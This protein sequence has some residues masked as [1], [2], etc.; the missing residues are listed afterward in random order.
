[1]KKLLMLVIIA[2]FGIAITISGQNFRGEV[3]KHEIYIPNNSYIG[4]SDNVD[5]ISTG[6][7]DIVRVS[8]DNYDIIKGGIHDIYGEA[9][10]IQGDKKCVDALIDRLNIT[11]VDRDA[12]NDK[13]VIYGYSPNINRCVKHK[14]KMVNIELV[15]G[16]NQIEIGT[17]LIM[18]SY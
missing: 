3:I 9:A 4:D 10:T 2:L 17:P 5:I 1:M 13:I 12:L 14:G 7:F 15:Y 8:C 16:N 11:I 6:A 18:G